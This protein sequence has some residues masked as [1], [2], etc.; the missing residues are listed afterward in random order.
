[1]AAVVSAGP[2]AESGVELTDLALD[3]PLDGKPD[4]ASAPELPPP[5]IADVAL[6]MVLGMATGWP[7]LIFVISLLLL[8]LVLADGPAPI[9]SCGRCPV[10]PT[11]GCISGRRR[12]RIQDP[13]TRA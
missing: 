7:V 4:A 9:V 13:R 5:S 8:R 10:S 11:A 1:M 12:Q 3:V 6:H 2:A